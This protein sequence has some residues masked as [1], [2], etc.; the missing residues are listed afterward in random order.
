[1]SRRLYSTC[2]LIAALG[3]IAGACSSSKT[4]APKASGSVGSTG[5]T[6]QA[7]A[8]LS[9]SPV[10]VSIKAGNTVTW[11]NSSGT[12]HTVTFENGPSFNQALNDGSNVSRMFQNPGTYNYYCTI[13]GKSMH[14][15][16]VVT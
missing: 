5:T 1:M 16:I 9:F 3:L 4:P 13:H 12:N 11:N 15:T 7:T 10:Q 2:A 14:G 8:Q 6:V